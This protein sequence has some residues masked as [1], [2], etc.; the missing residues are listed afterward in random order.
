MATIMEKLAA[1]TVASLSVFFLYLALRHRT[2]PAVAALLTLAFAFGTN[3]WTTSS[4]ALWQHGAAQLFLVLALWAVSSPASRWTVPLAGLALG[5]LPANRPPDLLLA[6]GFLPFVWGWA[7][8]RRLPFLVCAALPGVLCLAFNLAVYADPA[9]GYGVFGLTSPSSGFFHGSI[10]EGIAG[11]L[12]SPARGL[13]VYSPFFLF[14]LFGLRKVFRQEDQRLLAAG[15]LAAVA[16]QLL[17]YARTDWRAGYSWGYRFLTDLVPILIW[18]LV[19][20]V[21]DQKRLA[22]AAFAAA[23]LFSIW[24]QTLGAFRYLGASEASVFRNG[25]PS[26]HDTAPAWNPANCPILIEARS[27]IAPPLLVYRLVHL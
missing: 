26:D 24:V 13:F 5:L 6:L 23:L 22:R 14:L 9:G 11:L 19:P 18:L 4:Q 17:V 16:L 2:R 20:I 25:D 15:L 27:P 21:E 8:E 10:P 12:V 1:S 3:T 7:R